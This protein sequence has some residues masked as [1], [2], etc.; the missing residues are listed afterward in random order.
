MKR[1]RI[2]DRE[3]EVRTAGEFK[4]LPVVLHFQPCYFEVIEEPDRLKEWEKDLRE[5]VGLRMQMQ[6]QSG[7]ATGTTSYC[8]GPT[9][10]PMGS[11][12]Y[13]CDSDADEH[14]V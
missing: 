3:V 10:S 7:G 9:T 12:V 4:T 13:K 14:P 8:Q 11:T 1:I 5:R 6:G 2:D